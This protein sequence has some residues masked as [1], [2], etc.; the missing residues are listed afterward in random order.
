MEREVM[1]FDVVIV[2]AGPSGLAAAI[3]LKQLAAERGAELS[4][5]VLEKGSE[6]GAH[7]LSGACIE[8]RAL[9]ELL[10]DWREQG[11]PL[12]TP[13]KEDRFLYLT[14]TRAFRLSTPPQMRNHGNYIG[15][16][17]NLCRWLAERAEALGVEIFPGFAGA[18]L[19]FDDQGRVSGVGT[20]DAGVGRDGEPGPNFQPGIDLRARLTVLAEGC[21]GSLTKQVF[22]RFGLRKNA[23]HQTYG[24]GIKELWEIPAAKHE[25]GLVIHTIGWPLDHRTY[26]G[27][28]LY[29]YG[30]NLVSLGFVVGLDYENP[31]LSPFGELQRW[32]THPA[33]RGLLEGGRRIAYGA[34]ALSEGG[35]QS[36]PELVFPG[37]AL[38]GDCA[39]FLNVPK[40][41]GT[42]AAMKSGML[43]AEAAF[44]A[45]VAGADRPLLEEYPRKLR[46]SWLWEELYTARN[47][48]PA[49]K[50]GLFPAL[51]Y[52]ALD[53]YLF[54][55]KAPWTLRHRG[56]DHAMLKPAE[57]CARID[58]PKPD[59]VLT[60]DRLSS[61][62]V[63]NTNHEE[64]Q[65][66]HLVVRDRELALRVN[67]QTYRGPEERY[68]PAGVYEWLDDGRGG[69]RLQIN[70]Q[71]CVHCKT[72]DIKDP[73]QNIDWVPPE[74][75]GGPN[76]PGM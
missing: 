55:G 63:S 39:G 42:H 59:G 45:L 52:A 10:P 20:G 43:C 73:M 18:R 22:E 8:P 65:P 46:A 44:E 13:A 76:Y 60:F 9:D 14:A 21:R 66:C 33:I 31:W 68:C 29:M 58:Y 28:W 23:Q 71:N 6:V 38:V 27:S 40:I 74:G 75:G 64:N 47:I 56:P 53:T 19:L 72:C 49:F 67:W 69:K 48:R 37:G 2:G 5:C 54:R 17:G 16:L 25:P 32:K 12:S 51:A 70:A 15:S 1:E 36:L 50:W 34:R 41:K 62:F 57:A 24:I 11:A 61:V 35:F 4:V 3:R 26:G 7:I 30:E